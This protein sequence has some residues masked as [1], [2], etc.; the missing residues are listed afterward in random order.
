MLDVHRSRVRTEMDGMSDL[1][2]SR[3]GD[4]LVWRNEWHAV[5]NVDSYGVWLISLEKKDAVPFLAERRRSMAGAAAAHRWWH[6]GRG[7]RHAFCLFCGLD[8]LAVTQSEFAD[9][10]CPSPR[11]AGGEDEAQRILSGGAA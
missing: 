7:Y 6:D 4:R 8:Y 11:A 9:D 1:F 5:A 2:A 10:P 3:H